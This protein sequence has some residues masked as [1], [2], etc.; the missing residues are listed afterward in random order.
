METKMAVAKS[1]KEVE[2]VIQN[3]TAEEQR[4]L[5]QELPYLLKIPADD[6]CLLRLAESSFD[7]WDNPEDAVYDSL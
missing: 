4:R 7:F 3:M 1:I 6:L 2:K 5:L